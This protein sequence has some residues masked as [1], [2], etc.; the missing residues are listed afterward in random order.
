MSKNGQS[1]TL[2]YVDVTKGWIVT[3]SGNQTDAP[4]PLFITATGGC[5]TTCGDYKIHTF[6]VPGTFSVCALSASPACTA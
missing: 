1:I 2:V 4:G 6:S 3:D 5:I